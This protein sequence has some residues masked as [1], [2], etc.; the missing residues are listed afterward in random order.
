MTKT[1]LARSALELPPDERMELV[2]T[3]WQ[4]LEREP[5]KLPDWQRAL[6]DERIAE[7]ERNPEEGSPW[8]EVRK[9][10]WPDPA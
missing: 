9:R 10:V 1:D 2:E 6:L 7:L 8:E 3:L 5:A 4:S